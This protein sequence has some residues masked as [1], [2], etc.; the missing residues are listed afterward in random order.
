M[1]WARYVGLARNVY[2]YTERHVYLLYSQQNHRIHTVCVYIWFW[3]TLIIWVQRC[4]Q[5]SVFD[6]Q[7]VRI[8]ISISAAQHRRRVY[9]C[10]LLQR[11]C[12]RKVGPNTSHRSPRVYASYQ[13]KLYRWTIM[14]SCKGICK[15]PTKAK[16]LFIGFAW[17]I[18]AAYC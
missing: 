9:G 3:P 2:R 14:E 1:T 6:E 10:C 13:G 5:N 8:I 15:L 17:N 18:C 4:I 7:L 12:R 11:L 16:E